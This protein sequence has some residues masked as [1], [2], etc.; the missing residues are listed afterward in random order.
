MGRGRADAGRAPPALNQLSLPWSSCGSALPCRVYLGAALLP[1]LC[2]VS[3]PLL[4]AW[5]CLTH[6]ETRLHLQ[7]GL[8][9]LQHVSCVRVLYL[10]AFSTRDIFNLIYPRPRERWK[11]LRHRNASSEHQR[12]KG[13]LFDPST[14]FVTLQITVYHNNRQRMVG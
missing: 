6:G 9:A 13:L 14:L 1:S 2:P 7:V 11:S 10:Y 3:R 5:A 12:S 4:A 8:L